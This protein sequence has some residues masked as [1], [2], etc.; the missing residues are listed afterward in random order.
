MGQYHGQNVTMI[1]QFG[2]VRLFSDTVFV[3]TFHKIFWPVDAVRSPQV[4]TFTGL[5]HF[6]LAQSDV[7]MD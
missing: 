5:P 2:R 6:F 1:T 3:G 4:L 7:M